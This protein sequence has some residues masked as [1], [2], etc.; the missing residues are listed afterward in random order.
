M[1]RRYLS[2]VFNYWQKLT[3]G[4]VNRKILGAAFIVGF[5]TAFVKLAAF[6]KELVV[7][8][9]FGTGDEIDAFLI[10]FVVPSFIVNVVAASFSSALVPTYIKVLEKEG[11]KSADKLF[12][13]VVLCGLFLLGITTIVAVCTAPIY[14][15]WIASGFSSEK[16][17][18][19]FRLLCAISPFVLLSGMMSLW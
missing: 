16:L 11:R 13:G 8:W 15:P 5:L 1:K 14:L 2:G 3:S 9:R 4:S 12:S 17:D 19:T 7:A 6:V 10:A 18:L